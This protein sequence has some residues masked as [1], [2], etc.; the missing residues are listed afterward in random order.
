MRE[1]SMTRAMVAG[2]LAT[3]VMTFLGFLSTRF[4]F[5]TLNWADTF[6][7]WLGGGSVFG[8]GM[9]FILGIVMAVIYVAFFH[10][11]LPGTSW[12]RGLFFAVMLWVVTGAVLM[13]VLQ[14]GFFMG[15]VM[16]ALGTLVLYLFYGA[17]LGWI[18]DA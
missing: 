15:S 11:R 14:M 16:M 13:P 10:D 9:F 2:F 17:I 4:G 3:L 8:Y 7:T 12:R 18:Y 6:R 1:R 5:P